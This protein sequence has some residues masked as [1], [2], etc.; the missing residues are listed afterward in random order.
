MAA[1]VALG[2]RLIITL[3]LQVPQRQQWDGC[4][5]ELLDRNHDMP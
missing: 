5:D 2:L 1:K 3:S 4:R